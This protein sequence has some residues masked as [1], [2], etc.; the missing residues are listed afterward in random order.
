MDQTIKHQINRN[1]NKMM[2]LARDIGMEMENIQ[3]WTSLLKDFQEEK[4]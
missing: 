2:E 1:L 4:E 3:K